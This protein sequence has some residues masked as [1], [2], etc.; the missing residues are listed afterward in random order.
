MAF[1]GVGV[2]MLCVVWAIAI[3]V[4]AVLIRCEG[5]ITYLRVAV[6]TLALLLTIALWL[7]FRRD[8]ERKL[9]LELK[10]DEVIVYDYSVVGRT[11]VLAVTGTALLVGL[12]SVF[13][14]HLTEYRGA[15]RLPP[16]NRVL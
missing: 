2:I 3:V 1:I 8:Q 5:S 16:W 10:G 14:F 4:C 13:K 12:F 6:L 7:K 11:A 9:E 15:S